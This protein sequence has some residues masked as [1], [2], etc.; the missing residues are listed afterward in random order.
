[1]YA[2]N[3]GHVATRPSSPVIWPLTQ[4]L[5]QHLTLLHVLA[6]ASVPNLVYRWVLVE[7]YMHVA[8]CE[9]LSKVPPNRSHGADQLHNFA[10][11]N[12]LTRSSN[13]TTV[14]VGCAP[15]PSQC[16]ILSTFHS[17]FF[18]FF[19]VQCSF[20]KTLA[21]DGSAEIEG[22]RGM[23]S[24]SPSFSNGMAFRAFEASM[25]TR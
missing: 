25:T 9:E 17:T 12:S 5:V 22:T 21:W 15:T 6:L 18:S 14:V 13:F 24:Y 2:S 8:I 11:K 1:M 16:R 7:G 19:G 3:S 10:Q 23:G 20:P 4:T